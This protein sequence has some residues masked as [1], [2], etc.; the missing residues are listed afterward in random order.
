MARGSA[1]L[2]CLGKAAS[3]WAGLPFVEVQ[4]KA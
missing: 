4:R 1:A 2:K 3:V